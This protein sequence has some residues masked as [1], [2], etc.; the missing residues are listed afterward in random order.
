MQLSSAD[1]IA[2]TAWSVV[3]GNACTPSRYTNIVS[4]VKLESVTVPQITQCFPEF[5]HPLAHNKHV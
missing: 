1:V 5:P 3:V 2:M 4:V